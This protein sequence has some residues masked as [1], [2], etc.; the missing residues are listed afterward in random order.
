MT[1]AV[2]QACSNNDCLA[3]LAAFDILTPEEVLRFRTL[4]ALREKGAGWAECGRVQDV[5]PERAEHDHQTALWHLRRVRAFD[6]EVQ[7][8]R[9]AGADPMDFR[10]ARLLI[11]PRLAA[12]LTAYLGASA[13]QFEALTLRQLK[14]CAP[15]ASLLKEASGFSRVSQLS[16][17]RN[18]ESIA[19]QAHFGEYFESPAPVNPVPRKNFLDQHWAQTGSSREPLAVE[20][21][22]R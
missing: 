21:A 19:V 12:C 22:P 20:P 3:R 4:L 7:R 5:P 9:D 14:A 16:L 1:A 10:C 6:E 8:L 2:P 15:L 13:E 11:K 17:A 18:F